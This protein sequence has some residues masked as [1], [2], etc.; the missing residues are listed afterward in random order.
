MPK[1]PL[2]DQTWFADLLAAKGFSRSS[3][4]AFTNGKASIHVDGANFTADPGTGE[5]AWHGDLAQANRETVTLMLQQICKR[6][7][8]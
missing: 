6:V 8:P 2:A 7:T 1:A 5:K 4:T 3:P